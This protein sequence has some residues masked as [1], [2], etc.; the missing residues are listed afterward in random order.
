MKPDIEN[1][2]DGRK[3]G[4]NFVVRF[5]FGKLVKEISCFPIAC[6]TFTLSFQFHFYFIF[7]SSL[8]MSAA[9]IMRAN[10]SQL[11]F[12]LT[13]KKTKRKKA[14]QEKLKKQQ[15]PTN[16]Q[17]VQIIINFY[18]AQPTAA[19][20]KQTVGDHKKLPQ[21][22]YTHTHIHTET[23]AHNHLY[24]LIN[25]LYTKL[26]KWQVVVGWGKAKAY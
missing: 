22:I 15:N 26:V 8:S 7:C 16:K 18:L 5:I 12:A 19:N 21:G 13:C 4:S 2:T 11:T 1:D 14:K 10:K 25:M 6:K 9:D 17:L 20:V 3:R 24:V 23:H